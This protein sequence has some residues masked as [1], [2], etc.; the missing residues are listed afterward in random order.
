MAIFMGHWQLGVG[1]IVAI[2]VFEFYELFRSQTIVQHYNNELMQK[3][4]NEVNRGE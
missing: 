1:I 2:T 4:Y 3:I